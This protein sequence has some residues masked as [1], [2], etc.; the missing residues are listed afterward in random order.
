LYECPILTTANV[1]A[2]KTQE[3]YL[4]ITFLRCVLLERVDPLRWEELLKFESHVETRKAKSICVE[5]SAFAIQ[6][7]RDRCKQRNIDPK[8]IDF[9]Y[10]IIIVNGYGDPTT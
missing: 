1:P 4:C 10:G 8:S 5:Q 3:E 7:I 2:A 9:V 6:Y